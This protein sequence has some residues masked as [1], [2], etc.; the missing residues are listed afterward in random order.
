MTMDIRPATADEMDDFRRVARNALMAPTG[1]YP[2]EAIHAIRPEMTLCAFEKGRIATT[3]A[4]W[5][6]K[7]RFNGASLPVAGVTFVGTR[8]ECRRK[9]Y[10]SQVVTQ[11]FKALHETGG[12]S[13]AVLYASQAAIY[14]RFG[15]GIVST[16]HRYSVAPRDLVFAHADH[17]N[18]PNGSLRELA[19]D[20]MDLFQTL[21]RAFS[22]PRTGYLHRGAATWKSG[23]LW[24]PSAD[25]S[26]YRIVYEENGTPLGYVI[27]ALT[28][29]KVP[30]GQ[31]WQH[32]EINDLAWITP[33]AYRA[34]WHHLSVAG[35]VFEVAWQRVPQDD[36]LP[37]LLLEPRRLNIGAGDGL[38]A[39]V[40]DVAG[41]MSQRRY[42]E[43]GRFVFDLS[44]SLC[45]WNEGRW[46]LE[47]SPDGA[48]VT[49]SSRPADLVMPVDTLSM[50]LF[51]QISPSEAVRMGRAAAVGTG[52]LTLWDRVMQTRHKAFCPDFF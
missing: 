17:G 37:H 12:P 23:V 7:M 22:E 39:R 31:P 14:Q 38:L 28:G 44:D 4:A 16:H 50:L 6:L 10:L 32:I 19:D 13:M 21:Y 42:D 47:T 34:I 1:L 24:Q 15:F 52:D 25:V 30:H 48:R 41:A 40:V 35:L 49:R 18:G 9:G 46:Q 43:A 45:P 26:L 36:P 33:K 27:Y 20:E 51:G 11:H 2:P 8:P 29:R 5:P 3:H